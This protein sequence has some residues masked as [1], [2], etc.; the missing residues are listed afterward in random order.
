MF[1]GLGFLLAC[2]IYWR[3]VIKLKAEQVKSVE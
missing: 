2:S 1:F 3:E